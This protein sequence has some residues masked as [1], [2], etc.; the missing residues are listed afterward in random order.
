MKKIALI[1]T[2]CDTQEKIELL[3]KNINKIKDIG[4]DVM[5]ISPLKLTDE[6]IELADYTIFSKENPVLNWPEK[7]YFQWWGG[8]IN[9]QNITMRTTYPDYGYAGLVQVKR[10]ADFALSMDYEIGR[11]HV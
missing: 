6:I 4:V 3:T 8:Q 1:S 5:L 2:F 7:S 9:G 10:M 11:A